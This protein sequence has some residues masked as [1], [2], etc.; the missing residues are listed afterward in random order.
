MRINK[1][2]KAKIIKKLLVYRF[3]E[4]C[5]VVRSK[6][7]AFAEKIYNDVYSGSMR[8]QMHDLAEGWLPEPKMIKVQFGAEMVELDFSGGIIS[9]KVGWNE[10]DNRINR[11]VPYRDNGGND[12][13]YARCVKLYEATDK[14]SLDWAELI[15][16]IDDLVEE[17][18]SAELHI[19]TVLNSTTTTEGLLNKWPEVEPFLIDLEGYNKQLPALPTQKLNQLLDLPV[20]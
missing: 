5:A 16:E 20:S 18:D 6:A 12:S 1:Q 3:S 9:S 14:L 13:W 15:N 4:P 8:S 11:R 19:N 10:K 7:A 17:I 2:I